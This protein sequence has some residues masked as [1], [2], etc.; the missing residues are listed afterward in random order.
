MNYDKKIKIG[1]QDGSA[2][3]DISHRAQGP[4]PGTLTVVRT[5][6]LKLSSDLCTHAITCLHTNKHICTLH[7]H[8]QTYT[9]N[10]QT[11]SKIYNITKCPE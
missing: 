3:K 4:I 9:I 7:K 5:D 2:G 6:C 11:Q 8:T 1:H 10:K